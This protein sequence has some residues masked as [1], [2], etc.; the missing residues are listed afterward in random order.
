MILVGPLL[1]ALIFAAAGVLAGLTQDAQVARSRSIGAAL[2]GVALAAGLLFLPGAAPL[3]TLEWAPTGLLRVA[4]LVT[5][6]V[7]LVVVGV[8]PLLTHGASTFARMM[9][10]FAVAEAFLA[11][12]HPLVLIP[13]WAASSG[14][15]WWE[16][17]KRCH[18]KQAWHRVFGLYHLVSLLCFGGGALLLWQG[19]GGTAGVVLLL[20]GIAIREGVL[21]VHSWF[22]RFVE[23]APLGLVVAFAAPQL[24]AYAQLE[25]L[26]Q[27][28]MTSIAPVI[29]TMGA[30]TAVLASMLGVVQS[31]ARRALAYLILSQ[32]GLIAFGL[33]SHSSV[34][35]AGAL[36]HWQVLAIATSGFAMA[37]SALEARRGEMTL[38]EQRG[39]FRQTPKL[40][41][42]FLLLGF[43]SVGFPLTLGFVAEDL[44]VQGT[45]DEFPVLG[46]SLVV[47]TAF[48]GLS[49]LRAFFH[50]F[51]GAPR[52]T[53]E[54]DLGR[55][56]KFVLGV[57]MAA[58]LLW[59]LYPRPLVSFENPGSSP[60]P[61][62][63]AQHS[64]AAP[65]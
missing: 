62:V 7:A 15:A 27:S 41:S 9:F 35:L 42:A 36:L 16:L 26:E 8:A 2:L 65:R 4:P 44:L 17:R 28:D 12:D 22:P 47:A 11:T 23:H 45:V 63:E 32:T 3:E 24:G 52:S 39:D 19:G 64:A 20:A 53:G 60:H 13:L 40:G 31:S 5:A 54:P 61:G 51:T 30:V 55:R 50:L 33:E 29:A 25:L 1:L 57:A 34:G 6:L 58:L 37:L 43:A 59:G 38:G 10:L 21:P 56:E 49:V 14:I 46:L 18:Q 48:N